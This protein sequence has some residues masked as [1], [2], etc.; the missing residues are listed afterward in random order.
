MP[1]LAPTPFLVGSLRSFKN[2]PS[3]AAPRD[4]QPYLM[5]WDGL[6]R[7]PNARGNRLSGLTPAANAPPVRRWTGM[8]ALMLAAINGHHAI[9]EKLL[10]ARADLNTKSSNS[11]G[12]ALPR[13]PSG[14]VVGRRLCRLRLRRPT[15]PQRC[16]VRRTTAAPNPPWRCSSAAP[17]RP[18]RTMSG[19]AVLPRA[20][21]T[22]RPPNRPESAQANAS[23]RCTR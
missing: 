15:G 19:N 1:E 2:E 17:T 21:R 16:T 6:L 8:T 13:G 22:G 3:A 7:V 23:P 5:D 18:S 12:C 20:T 11:E 9:V 14:D 4:P 10:V